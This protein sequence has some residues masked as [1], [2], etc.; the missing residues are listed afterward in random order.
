MP[1]HPR[2]RRL[3]APRALGRR[4]ADLDALGSVLPEGRAAG[5]A[6][7]LSD[8]DVATLRHLAEAGMGANTL[9]A[10]GSDLGYLEAWA[11]ASTGSP[12]PWPAPLDL[13]LK[14][15]AQH[16]WDASQKSIDADHGMP[17][18]VRAE[19]IA[20]GV[21]RAAGPHAPGT[22][23]RRLSS[24][25]TLHRWRNLEGAFASPALRKAVQFAARAAP[26]GRRRKSREAIAGEVIG[27]LL[28]VLDEQISA[29]GL[30]RSRNASAL[31]LAALRDRSILS[32]G[33]AAGGRRRSEIAGLTC[34]AL[35][36]SPVRPSVR[37]PVRSPVPDGTGPSLIVDLGRTKTTDAANSATVV[38][39]G[40]P[41]DDLEAW[42]A[43]SGIASGPVYRAVSRW[44]AVGKAALTPQSVNAIVKARLRQAGYD[45]ADY[46]A[47]GLRSGYL[48]EAF[49]QGVSLPEAMGQSGHRSVNQAAAYFRAVRGTAGRAGRLL[50]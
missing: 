10:L 38:L 46:S 28:Q 27:R 8:A 26:R 16:L 33:F 12:L 24:W 44:G 15:V 40:R 31:S 18:A 37:S 32:F 5:L 25:S 11:L 47:H 4:V 19:L 43:G 14:F 20:A 48:T 13:V 30:D 36:R 50:G 17:E 39:I 34:E 6:D 3:D 45:P 42:L 29:I 23:R 35:E 1:E 41:I 9:R 21:L 49:L 22:V 7:L 2:N